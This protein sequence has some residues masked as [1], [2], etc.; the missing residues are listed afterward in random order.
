MSK[1]KIGFI[2]P[3]YNEEKNIKILYEKLKTEIRK[4]W[5]DYE[6]LFINDGSSDD[7]LKILQDQ[8]RKDEKVKIINFSRNFWHELAVKAWIDYS[9]WD[10][11]VIMDTDLQDPPELI[12]QMYQKIIQ[13]YDIVYGQRVTRSDWWFKDNTAKIFYKILQK[14]TETEIPI[15]TGNFRMFTKQVKEEVSKLNEQGRFI[16][17]LFARVWFK[18]TAIEFERPQR[19]YGKTAYPLKKMIKLSMD[20][21]LGFSSLP[22]KIATITGLLIGIIGIWLWCYFVRI[23]IYI[24]PWRYAA[25]TTTIITLMLIMFGLLFFFL[26]IIGEYVAKIFAQ[27]KNRPLYII[28][29]FHQ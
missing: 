21:I 20:A 23:K 11:I 2:L 13:G 6:L 17:W 16:R 19:K 8:R 25:W 1:K 27:S 22:L 15:N 5:C 3:I 14:A 26:W 10:Y 12:R 7:S 4:I 28:K 9:Q 24:D 18:T 29:D